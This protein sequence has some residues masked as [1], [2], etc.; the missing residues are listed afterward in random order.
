MLAAFVGLPLAVRL[1]AVLLV[2]LLASRL[3][4]WAIYSWAYN[5]RAIGPW[6]APP[7]KHPSRVMKDHLP[8]LGWYF[9][10][11]ESSV[12]GKFFWLRPLLIELCFPLFMTW[13]YS[14][15]IQGGSLPAGAVVKLIEPQL[16][17]Q[18]AGQFAL[19]CLMA[20]ATFIDF[21][22]YTIP[23][24]ITIPGTALGI[25]GAAWSP[26]WFPWFVPGPGFMP[27]ELDLALPNPPNIWMFKTP[28][29]AL[30]LFIL[31]IWG[32][33]LLD[34]RW[35]NRRGFKKAV[36][37]LCVRMFRG[38]MWMV[39]S[40]VTS[41][42][43]LFVLYQWAF[44]G[45]RWIYLLSALV[46]LAFAGGVTWAVRI[47]GTLGLGMEA[48]GFGDVT[49]MAMIGTF[50]GWQPSLVVF[51]LAPLVAIV[52]V[53]V[54]WII[55]RNNATP[56]GPYLCMAAAILLLGWHPIWTVRCADAFAIADIILLIV[57]VCVVLMGVM[58]WI[59]RLI[60]RALGLIG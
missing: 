9:L 40:A 52:F 15:Y 35:I 7:A 23:D 55:T 54:R 18:F 50:V 30:G 59:W 19:F 37:Y 32:F 42:M 6:A 29:L 43:M 28:G 58:L 47:A 36:Q 12:H 21:D 51:F 10:A 49:L 34:R 56:Y 20:V 25:V 2:G 11:R 8:I 13:Y 46:G 17:A 5:S 39:V 4:N 1:I 27:I 26:C 41:S 31:A 33:A 44:G 14:F 53:L 48:L 38:P 45:Q 16:H 60:K 22:E 24:Y 3:I 57:A